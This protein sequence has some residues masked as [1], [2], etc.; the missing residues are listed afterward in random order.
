MRCVASGFSRK[1]GAESSAAR[2]QIQHDSHGNQNQY[3]ANDRVPCQPLV[4]EDDAEQN[5][6]ERF[7]QAHA[8][9]L[10]RADSL[11]QPALQIV[12]VEGTEK[13]EAPDLKSGATEL[14]KGTKKKR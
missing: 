5:S 10:R 6:N 2:L 1:A 8:E 14:T 4:E 13:T 7:D 12:S 3:T 9:Q 11:Q